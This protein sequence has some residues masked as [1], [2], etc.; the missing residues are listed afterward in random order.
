MDRLHRCAGWSRIQEGQ[1][2]VSDE[3][4]CTSNEVLI[5]CLED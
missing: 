5:N 2:S 3:R 4:I 1:L